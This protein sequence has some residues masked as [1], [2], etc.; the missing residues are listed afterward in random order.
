MPGK[1]LRLLLLLSIEEEASS[2]QTPDSDSRRKPRS[3]SAND[4][5]E[6]VHFDFLCLLLLPVLLI[7]NI[8]ETVSLLPQ[9]ASAH[10]ASTIAVILF[11]LPTCLA[12]FLVLCS[13][14]SQNGNSDSKPITDASSSGK[15]PEGRAISS[16]CLG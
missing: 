10:G 6:K 8:S 3:P 5:R 12:T 14:S 11:S 9:Y 1:I 7:L 4:E 13:L 16:I 15:Y 2:L